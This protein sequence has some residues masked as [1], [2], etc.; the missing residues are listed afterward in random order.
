MGPGTSGL[1][2]TA[3]SCFRQNQAHRSHA[4]RKTL[5]KNKSSANLASTSFTF[6]CFQHRRGKNLTSSVK[7]QLKSKTK[8]E[9]IKQP[10]LV[11]Q[12][13]C[14]KPGQ[15]QD[16]RDEG[17]QAM[18]VMRHAVN[19]NT[20]LLLSSIPR[21][22]SRAGKC[23]AA[24]HGQANTSLCLVN[25]C[26]PWSCPAHLC[27]QPPAPALQT[28]RDQT[29]SSHTFCFLLWTGALCSH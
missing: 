3:S 15:R 1:S 16:C 19:N 22:E 9:Q 6:T 2:S 26:A 11:Q 7:I 5:R 10:I 25:A 18:C 4:F 13:D 24:P 12:Q 8:P 20:R 27:E 28:S 23:D 17:S 29:L 21:R 14:T